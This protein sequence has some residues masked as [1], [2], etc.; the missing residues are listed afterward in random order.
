MRRWHDLASGREARRD[1]YR[2]YAQGVRQSPAA[3]LVPALQLVSKIGGGAM[4]EDT[5]IANRIE[6]SD[7]ANADFGHN[8]AWVSLC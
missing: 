7:K 8:D 2:E 1:S 5:H 6:E 4:D 3:K